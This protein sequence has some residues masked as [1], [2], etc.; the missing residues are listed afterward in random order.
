MT[1]FDALIRIVA[2]LRGPEGCPWDRAQTPHSMRPYVVEEAYEVVEAIEEGDP[3]ALKKELGDLLFQVVLLAQMAEDAGWFS[4]E[5]VSR[6]ISDKMIRRHPHVF[7]PEHEEESPG[8]P[9]AWEALKAQERG[10][11]VSMLAGLP[12][13]LPA[14]VRAHRVGSKVSRAGFDWPDLQGVRDKVDEELA[15]LDAELALRAEGRPHRVEAEYGDVLLALSS[16]G[17]F[18]DVGPEEAL[19]GANQRFEGRFMEL[20]RR[21][22]QA[23]ASV[24][25]LD[26]DAL[27]ALWQQIKQDE[28]EA[29]D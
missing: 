29:G 6:A 20:E 14:L 9:A 28:A 25:A 22:L 10:A 15:E 2:Q 16:L 4:I 12:K 7:D 24:H 11:Q 19:R 17:R 21:A 26:A 23:G 3:E 1:S 13:A 5:D 27:E 8:S 18:V